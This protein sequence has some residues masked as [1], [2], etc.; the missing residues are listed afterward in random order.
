MRPWFTGKM[1][2]KSAL[3]E[4]KICSFGRFIGKNK[5]N[6]IYA[7]LRGVKLPTNEELTWDM[8][9]LLGSAFTHTH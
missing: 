1:K 3:E 8:G 2:D 7:V 5:T 4:R 9:L 6:K